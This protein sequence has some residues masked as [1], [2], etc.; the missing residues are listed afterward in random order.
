MSKENRKEFFCTVRTDSIY[1]KKVLNC[2]SIL[3]NRLDLPVSRIIQDAL[4]NYEVVTRNQEDCFRIGEEET[5]PE[6][7]EREP[8]TNPVQKPEESF[9]LLSGGMSEYQ[10]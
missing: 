6:K 5:L 4:L 1:G 7:E 3:K 8:E 9:S 10:M 2:V